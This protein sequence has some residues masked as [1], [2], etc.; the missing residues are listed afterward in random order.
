[1]GCGIL[2]ASEDNR[3]KGYALESIELV[4][5]YGFEILDCHQIYCNILEDNTASQNLFERCGFK[6]VG[7]KKE[8]I[9][10]KGKFYNEFLYQCI[11][12]THD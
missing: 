10:I 11:N 12:P 5:K 4:K 9:R 6:Y 7:S 2:I 3:R 1:V 8:W